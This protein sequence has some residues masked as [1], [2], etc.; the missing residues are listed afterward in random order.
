MER[1][2]LEIIKCLEWYI[3]NDD[4]NIGQPGNEYWEY[5]KDKAEQALADYFRRKQE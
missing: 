4:T 2:M 5:H 1:E 3:E